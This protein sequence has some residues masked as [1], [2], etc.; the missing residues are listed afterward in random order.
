MSGSSYGPQFDFASALVRGSGRCARCRRQFRPSKLDAH[1]TIP[2]KSGGPET[3]AN[4]EALCD[5]C[6]PIRERETAEAVRL[7]SSQPLRK[8][9]RRAR[10]PQRGSLANRLKRYQA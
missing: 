5:A 8:V 1:H 10:P 6:H 7:L 2:R 9:L 4:L 3:Y